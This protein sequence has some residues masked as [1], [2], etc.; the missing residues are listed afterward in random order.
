MLHPVSLIGVPLPEK[1][2]GN[3]FKP[4]RFMDL[5]HFSDVVVFNG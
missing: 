5:V 2:K 3:P 1:P 4:C